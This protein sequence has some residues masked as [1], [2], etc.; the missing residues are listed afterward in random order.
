[1]IC[2]GCGNLGVDVRP[3]WLELPARESITGMQWRRS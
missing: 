2:T 3:N 1:M